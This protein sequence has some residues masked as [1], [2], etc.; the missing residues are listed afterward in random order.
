MAERDD[1]ERMNDALQSLREAR[2]ELSAQARWL[3]TELSPRRMVHRTIDRHTTGA[4]FAAFAVGFG[5]ALLI[6]HKRSSHAGAQN[7]HK[8]YLDSQ[9]RRRGAG[10]GSALVKTAVPLVLKC[11]SSKPV[12]TKILN[13]ASPRRGPPA[14]DTMP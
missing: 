3:R 6:F 4:L 14:G 10:I 9:R 11:A 13:L 1:S 7:N 5:G 12:M 8:H 2:G